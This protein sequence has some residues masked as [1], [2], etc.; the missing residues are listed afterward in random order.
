MV[1]IILCINMA[2]LRFPSNYFSNIFSAQ[3]ICF[4]LFDAFL[5]FNIFCHSNLLVGSNI[6]NTQNFHI[7]L[8][9]S[10]IPRL[11][12]VENEFLSIRREGDLQFHKTTPKS[13][14]F[15]RQ[16]TNQLDTCKQPY[17]QSAG[18]RIFVR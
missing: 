10:L 16:S 14:T 12:L 13:E 4:H 1:C 18:N 3:L 6:I 8:I 7:T 17:S 11:A 9:D 15:K 2:P 5:I